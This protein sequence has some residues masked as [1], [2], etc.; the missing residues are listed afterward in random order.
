MAEKERRRPAKLA[1]KA[2]STQEWLHFL[3]FLPQQLN[4]RQMDE[5]DQAFGLTASGNA[6]IAHQW[7]LMSIRDATSRPI[8]GSRSF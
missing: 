5:L 1:T 3:R 4:A 6:E 7:L 8:R 2:W